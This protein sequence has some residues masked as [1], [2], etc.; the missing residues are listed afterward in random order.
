MLTEKM[1]DCIFEVVDSYFPEN[2]I[3]YKSICYL[4]DLAEINR[5]KIILTSLTCG[6]LRELI[7]QGY[8]ELLMEYK[9]RY[10]NE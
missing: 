7:E 6:D 1:S 3:Q 2:I 9:Y 8:D 4:C 10:E 5:D